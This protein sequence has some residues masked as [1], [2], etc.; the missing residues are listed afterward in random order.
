MP[1]AREHLAE[2]HAKAATHHGDAAD[3]H[4]GLEKSAAKMSAAHKKLAKESGL[5]DG[6]H[7]EIAAEWERRAGLHK[8]NASSH[9][10]YA[11]YHRSA[12]LKCSKAM[13]G[14]LNKLVPDEI[15]GVT[16]DRPGIR[17][18]PRAGQRELPSTPVSPEFEK[19]VAI[20]TGDE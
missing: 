10:E 6:P 18:I 3:H 11:D 8:G 1:S 13:E 2:F 14:D 15:S 7:T 19:L 5:T 4:D 12:A 9:R 16:P 20:E 17:A